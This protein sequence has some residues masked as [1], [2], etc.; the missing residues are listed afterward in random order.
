M[1][2]SEFS[3]PPSLPS[4]TEMKLFFFLLLSNKRIYIKRLQLKCINISFQRE[5]NVSAQVQILYFLISF[6]FLT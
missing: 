3:G 1:I 2:G 5:K 4:Q 6:P